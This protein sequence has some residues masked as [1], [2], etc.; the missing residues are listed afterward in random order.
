MVRVWVLHH[1]KQGKVAAH[2]GGEA[3]AEKDF[4]TG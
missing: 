4:E 2:R 1:S 3:P